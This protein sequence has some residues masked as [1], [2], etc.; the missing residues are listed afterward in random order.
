[1]PHTE[2]DKL[3]FDLR[4]IINRQA[5]EIEELRD[6]AARTLSTAYVIGDLVRK[7]EAGSATFSVEYNGSTM[8]W[9]GH[10]H[11]LASNDEIESMDC[12]P[13]SFDN[14]VKYLLAAMPDPEPKG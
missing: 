4:E 8:K 12:S 14:L 9:H 1:M 5:D 11:V 3:V 13:I 7:A 2:Q 10:M 6:H